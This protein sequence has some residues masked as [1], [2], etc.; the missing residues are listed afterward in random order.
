MGGSDRDSN[1]LVA[2]VVLITAPIAAMMLQAAISRTREYEADRVGADIS[3]QPQQLASA[4]QRIE[5]AAQQIPMRVS[6]TTMRSTAHM[7][8]VNPFSGGRF[9]SLFSSH[10]DTEDRV[11]RLMHMAR[12]GEYQFE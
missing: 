1:P 2:L 8:P 7:F 9:M 10:P 3:G 6:E 4:L 12:T 5:K 11:Q